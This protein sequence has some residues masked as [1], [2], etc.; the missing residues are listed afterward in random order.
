MEPFIV[1]SFSN[2]VQS[3]TKWAE[4]SNELELITFRFTWNI[5]YPLET[6]IEILI[7]FKTFA[8]ILAT[9]FDALIAQPVALP[10]S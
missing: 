3:I 4:T 7:Q 10:I 5:V 9:P 6:S 2:G 8:L 1:H